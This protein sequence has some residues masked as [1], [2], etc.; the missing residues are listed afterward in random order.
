MKPRTK[1]GNKGSGFGLVYLF[2]YTLN[3]IDLMVGTIFF[4]LS[5]LTCKPFRLVYLKTSLCP[6]ICFFCTPL[7]N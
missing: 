7:I 6:L 3:P 5:A 4:N 1:Y 2:I